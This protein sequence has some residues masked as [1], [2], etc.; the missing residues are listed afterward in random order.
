VIPPVSGPVADP[1]K[2]P[3]TKMRKAIATN[4]Q[5]S[6]QTVPHFYITLSVDAGALLAFAKARK[7][8]T[9]CS[10]NDVVMAGLGRAINEFPAVRSRYE[11]DGIVE[12]GTANIGIAVGLDDGLVVP[13]VMNVERQTLAQL[14][15]E[16]KRVVENARKGKLENIGKAVFT[17]SNLG[18]FGVEQFN[19]IINPPES[20]ILAVSAAREAVIVKDGAMKPGRLMTLTL[21]ADHRVV[22]GLLAAKFMARL[23][24]ILEAPEQIA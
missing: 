20:G 5:V 4:L 10:V 15:A 11:N 1:V 19:A 7:A 23:K 18:M 6:K 24:E 8:D 14:A 9:G 13:V 3:L 2:R 22:D 12:Y 17:V 21:S 16:T